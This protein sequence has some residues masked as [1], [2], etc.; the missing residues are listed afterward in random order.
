VPATPQQRPGPRGLQQADRDDDDGVEDQRD[1]R[2]DA[3]GVDGR[4]ERLQDQ[5]PHQRADYR[6]PA[7]RQQRS[8]DDHGEDRVELDPETGVVRVGPP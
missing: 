8:A 5:G 2:R 1:L 6:E 4:G 3:G 7:T